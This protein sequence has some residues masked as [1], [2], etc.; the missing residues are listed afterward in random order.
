[1]STVFAKRTHL[2]HFERG[3]WASCI[4]TFGLF[5]GRFLRLARR[6]VPHR[7]VRQSAGVVNGQD[8]RP[9]RLEQHFF[10]D[11]ADQVTGQDVALL[12]A[13]SFFRRNANGA[14]GEILHRA[15]GSAGQRHG[16]D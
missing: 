5:H 11:L 15:A 12:N 14:I 9:V 7:G 6:T 8:L 1:V 16:V 4:W 3:R 13:R 2:S 10:D